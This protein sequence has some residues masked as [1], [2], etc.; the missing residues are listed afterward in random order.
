MLKTFQAVHVYWLSYELIRAS[1]E[2]GDENAWNLQAQM[3]IGFADPFCAELGMDRIAMSPIYHI[4]TALQNFELRGDYGEYDIR[5]ELKQLKK[6]IEIVLSERI[7]VCVEEDKTN[8]FLQWEKTWKRVLDHFSGA[9]YDIGEAVSCF[10]V[11]SYTATVF[12]MLRVA[13]FGLRSL[14][15]TLGVI[16]KHDIE[17]EDWHAVLKAVEDKLEALQKIS[18]SQAREAELKLYSEAASHLRYLK[19]WRNEMAH[20]RCSYGVGE[21]ISSLTRVRE[22]LE[23]LCPVTAPSP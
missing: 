3:L 17:V 19:A 12:H 2:Y 7:F 4:R 13:E 1:E 14:A 8:E 9:K 5:A 11:Q 23:P 18:R 15:G 6:N 16:L 10:A 22:L 20:V 21:A